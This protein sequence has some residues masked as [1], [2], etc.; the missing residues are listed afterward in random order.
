MQEC[1]CIL[2]HY[3]CSHTMGFTYE[4]LGIHIWVFL[5]ESLNQGNGRILI[6]WHTEQKFK[7]S[8]KKY[9]HCQEKL[10]RK[11][12]MTL[13][14]I[15]QTLQGYQFTSNHWMNSEINLTHS[16][17]FENAFLCNYILNVM[18]YYASWSTLISQGV[19]VYH[20]KANQL[21]CIDCLLFWIPST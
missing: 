4:E 1:L 17:N 14:S 12:L 2:F 19:K 6:V 13:L 10:P 16:R 20:P 21:I 18:Y 3:T 5:L 11:S 9:N 7:L 15:L 8:G